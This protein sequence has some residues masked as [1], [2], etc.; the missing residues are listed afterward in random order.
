MLPLKS[1]TGQS[2]KVKTL[3]LVPSGQ[4]VSSAAKWQ[5]N[6]TLPDLVRT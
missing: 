2:P 1:A 3:I 4:L 5:E 6:F